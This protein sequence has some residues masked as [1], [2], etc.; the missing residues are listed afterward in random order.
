MNTTLKSTAS[1][2]LICGVLLLLLS[3]VVQAQNPAQPKRGFYPAGSYAVSDV[4]SVNTTN[5]NVIFKIPLVSLPAG[6]GGLSA[7][8]GLFY[9]SKIWDTYSYQDG[10]FE[11]QSY[12]TI[13]KPST[14]GG[15]RYGVKYDLEIVQRYQESTVIYHGCDDEYLSNW[16]VKM[17][18]PDGS[19]HVFRPTGHTDPLG[20]NFFRTNPGGWQY[21]CPGQAETHVITSGMTYY[22][23]DGTFMRLTVEPDSDN[24]P[25]NNAWTLS[26]PDGTRVT[27]GAPGS[28][29]RIT[30]RNGN[31]IEIRNITYNND[32]EATEIIDQLGRR[33]VIEHVPATGRDYIHAWRNDQYGQLT[34]LVWTV[35]WVGIG[36]TNRYYA[37]TE[38][39]FTGT[40]FG[41]EGTPGGISSI[42]LPSQMGQLAYT[43]EYDVAINSWGEVSKMTLP[44]GARTKYRFASNGMMAADVLKNSISEKELIYEREYDNATTTASE[45]WQYSIIEN[46]SQVTAPDQGITKEYFKQTNVATWDSGLV[47]KTEN[48]DGSIVERIWKQNIPTGYGLHTPVIANPYLK[49]EYTSIRTASGTLVKTAVKDYTYDKNG[50]LTQEADYDWVDYGTIARDFEG[51]PT[52]AVPSTPKRVSVS[53]Y[54]NPTPTAESSSAD[55]DIYTQYTASNARNIMESSEVRSGFA[56]TTTLS[57][58]ELSYDDPATTANLIQEKSWSST[59]GALSRPLTTTNSVSLATQYDAYG[60]PTLKTDANLRKTQ[61]VYGAIGGFSDLY[62]TQIK[63]A[64]ETSIVRTETRE[65]DFRNGQVT[66]TTDVDNGVSTATT[67][68][69]FARPILVR[70]AEGKDEETRTA[71]EY[72]DVNRRVIVR[73]DLNLVGDGLLVTVQHYDQLGRIRLSRQLE[74]AAT[75][76]ATDE[77]TGIKVQTRYL[78]S[79][80]NSY[81]LVSNPYRA[82][83]SSGAG[84]EAAMGWSRTKS[85]NGGR[86]L[87]VQTFAG[88]ALP[89][90]WA[91][92]SAATGAVTT[93]YDAQFTTVTDQASKKRRSMVDGLGRLERVDEPDKVTGNLDDGSGNPLQPT[94]YTYDA[95]GNLRKVVQ[96]AQERFFM[97]DS[98]SRL[99]RARNPEQN[100]RASL[101]LTDATTGNGQWTTGYAY[102]DHGNMT[103][104]TDARGVVTTYVYDALQRA[105]NRSYSDATPA[106]TNAYDAAGVA[107]SRGRLTSV[108][109]S[110]SLNSITEYDALGR[111]KSGAQTLSGHTYTLGYSY[112]LASH[113]KSITYPSNHVVSYV[114]DGAG[115]T[116][117]VTGTL[118]DGALR[119]YATGITYDAANR[120]TQE[121]F[122]TTTALY[123]KLFYTTRGQLAEIRVGITPNNTD[124]ERGAL[125]NHYSNNYGCWGAACIAPDNNGNLMKQE[126]HIPSQT[127]KWQEFNYDQLNRLNWVREVINGTDQWKQFF[128]YDRYG[129]RLIDTVNTWGSGIPKPGF[130]VNTANNHLGVPGGQSGAMSYD[131]A[132]NLTTDTYSAAAVVRAYDAENRMTSETQANSVVG[133]SY[134]YDGDGRRVKRVVGS[135]E[136]W[137]LF[138]TSSELLAEYPLNGSI[139][140]PQKEYAYRDGQLLLTATSGTSWG[141]PPTLHDNPLVARETTV[142]SRHITELRDAINSLRTHL[143]LSNYSWQYQAVAVGDLIKADPILEMRTALDQALGAPS[144]AYS[145]GLAQGQPVKAVHIQEL[146]NRVLTA[147]SDGGADFRWLVADQLG[148]PRMIF[149]LSGSLANTSRH[150]YLPFGEDL[151]ASGR[152]TSLGYGLADGARQKFT[153]KERDDE[154][155]LDYFIARYYSYTQGRFTSVDPREIA[156]ENDRQRVLA[157]LANPQNWNRYSYVLN[158]P[159][160]LS[161]PDGREPNKS[162]AGTAAQI[163]AIIKATEKGNPNATPTEILQKVDGYFRAS[164]DQPGDTRYVYTNK[165]GWIDAKHFIAAAN[166]AASI[167]GEVGTNVSGLVVELK[168]TVTGSDSA[169]SY[170][171]LGSNAAGADFGDDVFDPN[172]APLSE[173]VQN[174]FDNTLG[175]TQPQFAPNYNAIPE[176]EQGS[177]SRRTQSS[178]GRNDSSSANNARNNRRGDSP[179]P[180][181]NRP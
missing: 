52:G 141:A 47:Y 118:G 89:A 51:K 10:R 155:D 81:Q 25:A 43:F 93:S 147:W 23:A 42:T 123:N 126:I 53:T 144:P 161:D 132:G 158:N 162:Q 77:T 103:Q 146:R 71:T 124:W 4:E 68:D 38:D 128:T 173:Q 135:T 19:E 66:R 8:V 79:S 34:E 110:V 152:S 59:K 13:I 48:P 151:L 145:T 7:G 138:G 44:S 109:S 137:Q 92:N 170:E 55:V 121:Q 163:V 131:D 179:S 154:T 119:N 102:D 32:P 159:L 46:F 14:S 122:G 160:I 174:Y 29:E 105:T 153:Q 41:P 69:L 28:T 176:R 15:W 178:A 120:L 3:A 20:D 149:D 57:R 167:V 76:I 130:T 72:S 117:S 97:Y 16:K 24:D 50:N 113:V 65:Y 62:P 78:Y 33:V 96:G 54:Y 39:I 17:K 112:D 56:D 88:S 116:N 175:A 75:Q 129:N 37:N 140:T 64:F 63:T 12:T 133:G 91:S 5:G 98:R 181:R 172:G 115:R 95:L 73:A 101:N 45:L 22:S 156:L 136:T 27:S 40:T 60:N 6:R 70:A 30:D 180:Q 106:V 111:M 31:Y 49:T 9:N 157:Y 107:N 90:P 1:S 168:Q 171:D 127:M 150:D 61:F 166:T 18:F 108:S 58:T 104:K 67:Y 11:S 169:F 83:A 82:T 134:S 177:G 143:S 86:V 36:V 164:Q 84:T 2:S 85:D 99:I 35:Q 80:V 148:T 125:I 100:V 165:K 142:Q 87:E 26:L 94:T 74:N 21:Q 114:Y 139:A